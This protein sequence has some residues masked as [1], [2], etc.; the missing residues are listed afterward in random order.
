MTFPASVLVA[1][2][3]ASVFPNE[4]Y[5]LGGFTQIEKAKR[6]AEK[7]RHLRWCVKQDATVTPDLNLIFNKFDLRTSIT[8]DHLGFILWITARPTK[9]SDFIELNPELADEVLAVIE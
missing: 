9:V 6:L 3:Q 8:E 1:I 5:M 7:I 4:P 2:R